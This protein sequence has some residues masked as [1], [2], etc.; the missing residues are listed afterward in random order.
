M[1][2][3]W[4]L[5]LQLNCLHQL[6]ICSPTLR[7]SYEFRQRKKKLQTY[8]RHKRL[9]QRM[10]R[11]SVCSVSV[12]VRICLFLSLSISFCFS[13]SLCLS[14]CLGLSTFVFV[15]LTLSLCL[16]HSAQF[17][18]GKIEFQTQCSEWLRCLPCMSEYGLDTQLS[19]FSPSPTRIYPW[20]Q[21]RSVP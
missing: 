11:L 20:A 13:F 3:H 7:I 15:C 21:C 5:I 18:L 4:H 9:H 17:T 1:R 14:V 10:R 8:V 19:I 6:Q 16:C 2:P 12:S